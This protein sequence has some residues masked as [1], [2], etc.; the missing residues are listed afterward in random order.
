MGIGNPQGNAELN[1]KVSENVCARVCTA[2]DFFWKSMRVFSL[3]IS[4]VLF[5]IITGFSL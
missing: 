3:G 5:N 4:V 2:C 1:S